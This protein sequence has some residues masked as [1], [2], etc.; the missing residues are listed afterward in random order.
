MATVVI[1]EHIDD[2]GHVH[3]TSISVTDVGLD[4]AENNA[5]VGAVLVAAVAAVM[6][7]YGRPLD[8]GVAMAEREA[9]AL[10]DGSRLALARWR[11]AV[12]AIGRDYLVWTPPD[13]EEPLAAL[14]NG[15]AAALRHLARAAP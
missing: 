11:A 3:R 13:G 15:I 12:D 14:S 10:P 4:V 1:D 9:L 2:R 7:R 8:G 6:R 5:R